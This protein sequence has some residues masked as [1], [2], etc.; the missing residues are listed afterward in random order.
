MKKIKFCIVITLAIAMASCKDAA[1][2]ADQS[3]TSSSKAE[4]QENTNDEKI[5]DNAPVNST[6]ADSIILNKP[7]DILANIDKYLVSKPVYPVS[8]NGGI[9]NGEVM[10]ENTLT[11]ATFQKAIVEV[12]ILLPDG[13]EYRTDYYT[14][15]NIEPQTTRTVKI[16]AT[17]RGVSVLSHIVKVKSAELTN[18]EWVLVGRRYVPQ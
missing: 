18:G 11:D 17:T 2:K 6:T 12:S 15:Q 14:V 9:V 16:P 1:T 10:I 13:K 7:G 3:D 4:R 5:Q 8:I